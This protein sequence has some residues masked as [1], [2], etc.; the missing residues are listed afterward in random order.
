MLNLNQPYG[1][2]YGRPGV[3]FEQGGRYYRADFSP[4]DSAALPV[5]P[6]DDDASAAASED[7]E[8]MSNAALQALVR[9]YSGHWRN[10]E[11]AIAF[12]RGQG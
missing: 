10:R 1:E 6:P 11:H 7:F 4:L 12:L 3:K 8:Q 9:Q 5:A 2:V